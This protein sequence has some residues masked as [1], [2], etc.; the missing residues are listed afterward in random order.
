MLRN[1]PLRMLFVGDDWYGS[2]A[3]S[4][5]NGFLQQGVDVTTI[6]TFDLASPRAHLHRRAAKKVLPRYYNE[7]ATAQVTKAISDAVKSTR[8]DVM[9]VFKGDFVEN[10]A[11]LRFGG[12]KVHYHPDDSAKLENTSSQYIAAEKYYDIHITTKL[13]NVNEL[14]ARTDARVVFVQCAYDPAWHTP[15]SFASI[16][17]VGL[18]GTRRP[19]RTHFMEDCARST[20]QKMLIAGSG[21]RG[22]R[23]LVRLAEVRGPQFGL[24]FS[25]YASQA[26]I[27][28]GVLNSAN[29]DTHTCR[30]FEIPAA[31][32]LFV[33]EWTEEHEEIFSTP[34]SAML[35]RNP[36]EAL[37]MISFAE[38]NPAFVDKARRVGY[39]TILGGRNTYRDRASDLLRYFA[40][41]A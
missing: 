5:R 20:N 37:D 4:L 17:R 38:G 39:A 18:I 41:S 19:D 30:T 7:F 9:F 21:W 35:Y 40:E 16:S 22:E 14:K 24:D 1:E 10:K 32:A 36:E 23:N 2:N 29:R 13:H 12:M 26:P 3:T 28:L 27:Q 8:F 6:N 34:N 11:I 25:K 33:G 15:Q 31:G